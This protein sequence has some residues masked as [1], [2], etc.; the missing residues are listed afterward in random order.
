[1][2]IKI[3][4]FSLLLLTSLPSSADTQFKQS[5]GFPDA[6]A[7]FLSGCETPDSGYVF[8]GNTTDTVSKISKLFLVKMD[9]QGSLLWSKTY[10]YPIDAFGIKVAAAP[11]GELV[12]MGY[13]FLDTIPYDDIFLIRT[14]SDG[15]ILW[16]KTYGGND[17]DEGNDMII[18]AQGNIVVAGYTYSFGTALK[19]GFVLKTDGNGIYSWSKTYSQNVNQEFNGIS[20]TSDYGY[21]LSGYTQAPPGINFDGY[22]VK[23]DSAGGINWSK[24]TGGSLSEILY[25]GWQDAAGDYYFAGSAST[26]TLSGNQDGWLLKVNSLGTSNLINYTYGT[27][28]AERTYSIAVNATGNSLILSGY[29]LSSSGYE[30]ALYLPINPV[31]GTLSGSALFAGTATGNA[32]ALASFYSSTGLVQAGYIFT[33][34]D[35]LGS[36]YAVKYP[37]VISPCQVGVASLNIVNQNMTVFYS[38][39]AGTNEALAAAI[40]NNVSFITGSSNPVQNIFCL[41]SSTSEAAG[42]ESILL[43]PNPA[44]QT[45]T[46]ELPFEQSAQIRVV[47]MNGK[48]IIK[49]TLQDSK[50]DLLISNL[51]SGVYQ[52]VIE[53]GNKMLRKKFVK[54]DF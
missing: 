10:E 18:D 32:R 47:D 44:Q 21:I 1:M 39:S 33:A 53:S 42:M 6:S 28:I 2:K 25:K 37:T 46:V 8:L 51:S 48:V 5:I 50:T 30:N 16:S 38:D 23:T 35:T 20:Q 43:S 9:L 15:T 4:L 17:I 45:L 19:S 31:D 11:N 14:L 24:R 41:I 49:T 40:T 26:N 34:T 22:I 13:T 3:I 29:S 27:S 54:V 36:A 12:M 52:L 7:E